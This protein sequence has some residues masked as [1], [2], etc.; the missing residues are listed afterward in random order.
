MK[1]DKFNYP[2]DY[3][4]DKHHF[5]ARI[6]G[7]LVIMG[8]TE[9]A[10]QSAGELVFVQMIDAGKNVQQ[11]KPFLSVES[12]KWVGRVFAVVSG[13]VAE[14]NEELEFDPTLINRDPYNEGWI[15]KI[16]PSQLDEELGNLLKSDNLSEWLI[17]EIERQKKLQAKKGF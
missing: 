2:D 8:M 12:G 16:R 7:D 13:E 5:W 15:A 9:Y 11:D 4:F 10:T 17:P 6:D 14:V 3:Y 1:I